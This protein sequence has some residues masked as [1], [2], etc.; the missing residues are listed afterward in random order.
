MGCGEGPAQREEPAHSLNLQAAQVEVEAGGL[1]QQTLEGPGQEHRGVLAS[2][3]HWP[4][5]G[6]NGQGHLPRLTLCFAISSLLSHY[7]PTST[8]R[9]LD[10]SLRIWKQLASLETMQTPSR[11]CLTFT[12]LDLLTSSTLGSAPGG[13]VFFAVLLY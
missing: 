7:N 6:I 5:R 11:S 1:D 8:P 9:C 4:P 3:S 13:L 10:Q 12:S 2:M